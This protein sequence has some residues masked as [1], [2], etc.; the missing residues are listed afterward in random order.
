V[1]VP[2]VIRR[3]EVTVISNPFVREAI[4]RSHRLGSGV[5]LYDTWRRKN[6]T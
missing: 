6:V 4:L 1:P 2:P 5:Y 3:G